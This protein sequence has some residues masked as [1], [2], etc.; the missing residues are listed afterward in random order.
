MNRSGPLNTERGVSWNPHVATVRRFAPATA[1]VEGGDGHVS[2]AL[3]RR[4]EG[5]GALP[6]MTQQRQLQP[7]PLERIAAKGAAASLLECGGLVGTTLL[8]RLGGV[9]ALPCM[10]QQRQL[11]PLPL[12]RIAAMGAVVSLPCPGRMAS[13]RWRRSP[14][15]G[16]DR[17]CATASPGG[18]DFRFACHRVQ[19]LA[20]RRSPGGRT[21]GRSRSS[22]PEYYSSGSYSHFDWSRSGPWA[23]SSVS[24]GATVRHARHCT[25]AFRLERTAGSCSH[26]DWSGSRPWAQSATVRMAW[27]CSDA[28]GASEHVLMPLWARSPASWSPPDRGA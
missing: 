16:R 1:R 17:S 18:P 8:R 2:A 19:D 26:S 27:H 21:A 22:L 10:P 25:D 12:E 20:R 6:C 9:G 5:V 3:H 24:S 4:L 7:L 15:R 13:S 28:W 23:R 11:Q 14:A